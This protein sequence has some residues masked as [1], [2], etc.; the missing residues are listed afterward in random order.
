MRPLPY[1]QFKGSCPRIN[2]T[3]ATSVTAAPSYLNVKVAFKALDED[4][5][6]TR[7]VIPGGRLDG[8]ACIF[9]PCPDQ[10]ALEKRH[11]KERH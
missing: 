5:E 2:T 9:W 10:E 4:D 7:H 3:S 11:E 1:T 8:L 6:G